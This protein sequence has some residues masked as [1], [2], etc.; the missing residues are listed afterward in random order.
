MED[1]VENPS[2]NIMVGDKFTFTFK[3]EKYFI[4]LTEDYK[5]KDDDDTIYDTPSSFCNNVIR[6][7]NID[8]KSRMNGYNKVIHVKSGRKLKEF[9]T[10]KKIKKSDWTTTIKKIVDVLL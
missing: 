10:E 8:S 2:N 1:I 5:F 9:S 3:E 4:V 7:N 6:R